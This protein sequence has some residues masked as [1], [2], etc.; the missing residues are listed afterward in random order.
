MTADVAADAKY[1][2]VA[3]VAQGAGTCWVAS[4]AI[5]PAQ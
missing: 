2:Q 5:A 3:A 1:I 4:F